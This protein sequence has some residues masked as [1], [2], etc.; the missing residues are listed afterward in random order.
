MMNPM[1]KALLLAIAAA[2]LTGY[3]IAV[4]TK[5]TDSMA[6]LILMLPVAWMIANKLEAVAN[7]TRSQRK[8]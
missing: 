5:L 1:N 7:S 4:L 8:D 3:V 6:W 2:C